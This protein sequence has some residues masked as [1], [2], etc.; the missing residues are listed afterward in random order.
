MSD[1]GTVKVGRL[2]L[3]EALAVASESVNSQTGNRQLTI[4]GQ[5]AKPDLTVAQL[6]QIQDDVQNMIDSMVPVVFTN[7]SDRSGY[8][9]VTDSSADLM[10]WTG[11]VIT[12]AWK[13]TMDRLGS[14]TEVD[15]ESRLSGATARNNSFAATGERWHAPPI[16]HYGYWSG[17]T[18]PSVVTRTGADGPMTVYRGLSAT[19]N[20]RYGCAVGSYLAGRVRFSD[21]NSAERS[22]VNF[23]VAATGWTLSNALVQVTA[24]SA[25][26]GVL[27]VSA[28]T[29]G[30]MQAKAWDL[31]SGGVS[32]GVPAGAT[33]L[34]NDP[35]AVTLRLLW[36]QATPGRVSADLVLRRGSRFV[37][38]YVQGEFSSTLKL[39]RTTAEAGTSGTG[40]VAATA[41]DA[42]GN[43]YIVG[44]ALT[45]TADTT[46]GGLSL[47]STTALDAFI[48]VVAGGGAAVAGDQA[49][50]LY[51]QYLGAPS[52]STQAV[53]R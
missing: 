1:F 41:N 33:V 12:C 20:P 29:G 6:A 34:R 53:R 13:L 37:E 39:V 49:A 19:V 21:A 24:A 15:V 47:A 14:D 2:V 42:A 3:R 22:G 44:S 8:Y 10:N 11:E 23:T 35:E 5:E 50:D 27:T 32:L 28:Y 36:T 48:G 31:L 7:K 26:S 38:L 52:E 9:Q 45:F 46:L 43:R 16:G 18:Q 40:Y 17:S 51:A 4:T 25:G 30:A